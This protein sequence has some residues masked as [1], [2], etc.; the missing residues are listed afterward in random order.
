MRVRSAVL[1]A[2]L[3]IGGIGV[4]TAFTLLRSGPSDEDAPAAPR[5]LKAK[6]AV[7]AVEGED[8]EE[9]G[10]LDATDA[11]AA[12]V[13]LPDGRVVATVT[14]DGRF[15]AKDYV[16]EVID[17][18]SGE[19]EQL[20]APWLGEGEV[21]P[22]AALLDDDRLLVTWADQ[23]MIV[24]P[25]TGEH[26]E[27]DVPLPPLRNG[28]K[29]LTAPQPT[30]DDRLWF[31]TGKESCGDGECSAP[32]QGVLWSFVPGDDRPQREGEAVRFAVGGDL[33]AFTRSGDSDTIH[34]RNVRSGEEHE[35]AVEGL[36][37]IDRLVASDTIVVAVCAFDD[38]RQVAIDSEGRKIAELRL[39]YEP[40]AVSDRWILVSPFAYD[41]RTGR[42]VRFFSRKGADFTRPLDGDRTV[43]PVGQTEDGPAVDPWTVLRLTDAR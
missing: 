41:T 8:Y 31:Q 25:T 38:G 18:R 1:V 12:Q 7:A 34:L 6:H 13:V 15:G 29:V 32:R 9:I 36:C 27:H 11:A 19:R 17:P 33:L 24:D 5:V 35:Y 28:A 40:A 20:P 16:L 14:R 39:S 3:V 23:V 2:L 22:G 4:V 43:L 10:R 21:H 30:D 26:E 37:P 42:L